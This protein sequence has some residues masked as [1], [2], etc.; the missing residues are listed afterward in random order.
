MKRLLSI[1]ATLGVVA[2]TAFADWDVY[3][4]VPDANKRD[5]PPQGEW[6][7]PGDNSCW[8]ASA[9]NL[10]GAAGYGT[11]DDAQLRAD[12]MYDR[13]LTDLGWTSIGWPPSALT[14]WL[15]EYGKN[16]D[17]GEFKPENSYTDITVQNKDNGLTRADYNFL[18]NELERGQYVSVLWEG[19]PDHW[20]TLVGGDRQRNDTRSVWRDSD[21]DQPGPGGAS[22]EDYANTFDGGIW[23]IDGYQKALQYV[24]FCPGLNKPER[25]MREYDVAYYPTD[26]D[27]DGTWS[28]EFREAGSLAGLY[29]D[30]VWENDTTVRIGNVAVDDWE[31]E[32]WLLVDY[33]DVDP[34]RNEQVALEVNGQRIDPTSVT[35]SAGHGQL[36]FYWDLDCQPPFEK[37]LFPH[38]GYKDLVD[39]T[40]LSWDVATYCIPAPTPLGAITLAGMC[41]LRR[42]RTGG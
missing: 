38:D 31:K 4:L 2:G 34:N 10:L 11:G 14:Y 16:P 32:I 37:L 23:K 7:D 26:R 30:P 18:L 36:L 41:V 15:C 13:L 8:Q 39:T 40:I 21:K 35:A 28:P 19:D 17:S 24:T 42:R 20:M 12:S 6:P 27:N 25:A 1:A 29:D 22:Q 9:A 3:V 33:S 5:R